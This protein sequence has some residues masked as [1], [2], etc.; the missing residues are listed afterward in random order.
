VELD[1]IIEHNGKEA[2]QTIAENGLGM[3]YDR[4][5]HRHGE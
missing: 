4:L 3:Q 5:L 2:K 1:D